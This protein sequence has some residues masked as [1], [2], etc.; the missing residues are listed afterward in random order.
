MALALYSHLVFYPGGGPASG[1]DVRVVLLG[2]NVTPPLFEDRAGTLPKPVTGSMVRTDADGLLSFY[3]APALFAAEFAGEMFM[4]S[5][6]P[7]ETIPAHPGV[8][9]HTQEVPATTWT[10]RHMMGI[11]PDVSVMVD[12]TIERPAITHP[13]ASTTVITFQTP[14]AGVAHLRR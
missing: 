6:D 1:R 10:I 14:S 8:F 4:I 3:A 11:E 12:K 13:D 2:S 7:S 5:V 9:T